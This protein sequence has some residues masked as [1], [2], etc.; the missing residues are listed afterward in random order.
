MTLLF[1]KLDILVYLD[2]D[3]LVYLDMECSHGFRWKCLRNFCFCFFYFQPKKWNWFCYDGMHVFMI[4]VL[5]GFKKYKIMIIQLSIN[6]L[7][8]IYMFIRSGMCMHLLTPFFRILI[9][10]K[11]WNFLLFKLKW[12]RILYYM[13]NFSINMFLVTILF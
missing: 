3:I 10:A 11:R 2:I 5:F 8:M 13:I 7:M 9:I 12:E 1:R 4:F 6:G